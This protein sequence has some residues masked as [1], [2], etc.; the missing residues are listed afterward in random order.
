MKVEFWSK[1]KI[2]AFQEIKLKETLNY[3]NE[4]SAFY[5]RQFKD[6]DLNSINALTDLQ[7]L[8]FTTK[9]DLQQYNSDFC[10]YH[11]TRW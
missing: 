4:N 11:L 8:P 1:E 5:K 9:E 2:A 10:A 3:V 6:F 7:K